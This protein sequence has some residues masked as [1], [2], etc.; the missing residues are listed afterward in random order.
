MNSLF[1]KYTFCIFMIAAS[2]AQAEGGCPAGMIPASGNNI[3]SCVPIPPGYY[4]QGSPP[5]QGTGAIYPK[6]V[7]ADR[8]GAIAADLSPLTPGS[9]FNEVSRDAAEKAAIK[10]CHSNGGI[11][12]EVEI[13]YG[14]GCVAMVVG[15]TRF[16]TR[17]GPTIEAAKRKAMEQ[18]QS[19]DM[20]CYV[21][22][23]ACSLPVRI[24]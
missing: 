8:Y 19:N 1:A 9:S 13:S 4:Q 23:S 2:G 18:C 16:N 20:G 24:N 17:A 10:S 6:P 3:N 12:C 21:F 5:A 15:R 14:N 7:W 11:N 22:Y